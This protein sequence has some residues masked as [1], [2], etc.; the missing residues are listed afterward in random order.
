MRDNLKVWR[1]A[2]GLIFMA[3]S[4]AFAVE[5][6]G[7]TSAAKTASAAPA[8]STLQIKQVQGS[9]VALDLQ[10]LLPTVTLKDASGQSWVLGVDPKGT[11]VWN[12]SQLAN[13]NQLKVGS[14]VK[15]RYEE[16]TARK[17]A[18]WIELVQ[19]SATAASAT[20]QPASQ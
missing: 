16:Q 18:K 5:H 7:S 20:S 1:I 19:P 14:Q 2:M 8:A 15:I 13:P 3:T 4:A 12:G 11:I 9:I 6:G 17:L 10:S